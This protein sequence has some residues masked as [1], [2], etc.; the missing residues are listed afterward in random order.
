M[1]WLYWAGG[2]LLYFAFLAVTAPADI[3][4]W[5]INRF[6]PA[7]VVAEGA[8][9]TLWQGEARQIS[10]TPKGGQA[11]A[12]GPLSWQI[13]PLRL[14]LGELSSGVKLDGS[15]S[16]KADLS[17]GVQRIVIRQLD[18]SLP[19]AW[20]A[21]LQPGLDLWQPGGTLTLRSQ[22]FALQSGQYSGQGEITWE[23]AVLGI[24]PVR[25][26]GN[27]QA[28]ISGAG[29]AIQFQVQTRSGPLELQGNGA[30]TPLGL[31]FTGTAWARG[32][33]VELRNLL[34]MMGSLKPDGRYAIRVEGRGQRH[35]ER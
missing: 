3:L 26:L 17:L 23:Q 25:P 6:G 13:H 28:E 34:G 8:S 30:W 32:R 5:A 16:G 31:E 29:K 20:L 33:E 35:P 27:Y 9:G 19:A 11:V 10:F 4:L 1:R 14:L 18:L 2:V 24:S 22:D 15:V 21:T 12:I 7:S